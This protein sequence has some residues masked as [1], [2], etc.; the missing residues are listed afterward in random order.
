MQ[1]K[2]GKNC[3]LS[4]RCKDITWLQYKA[5]EL[6]SLASQSPFTKEQ[7]YRWHSLCFPLF[8]DFKQMFYKRGQRKLA[9]N[10]LDPL[11][12]IGLAIW[13]ADCGKY[14]AGKVTF[15]T[16]IW[17]K[18]G[19]KIIQEY[20][21]LSCFKAN[22]IKNKGYYRVV[23]DERSSCNFLKLVIPQLPQ[24]QIRNMQLY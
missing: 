19:S 1:P 9:T 12:D 24:F 14:R 3:Y 5:G 17:G 7:T 8:R 22:L 20:F 15:N 18:H 21:N 2:K 13:F 4:M 16:H 11:H 10:I 23:L 6:A